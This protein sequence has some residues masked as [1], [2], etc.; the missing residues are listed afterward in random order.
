MT[1]EIY[2]EAIRKLATIA[3]G[4]T[5][6]SRVAAQVLLSAYNGQAFQVNIVDLCIF[7]K[8]HY[9]A[10]LSVIRGRNELGTEPHTLLDNGDQIF[11]ELWQQWQRYHVENRAKPT[12][13]LCYGSGLIPEYPDDENNYSQTTCTQCEGRGY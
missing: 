5:G 6:G 3:Q 8:E 11:K 10:A 4:D 7:D 1:P 13:N 12:C 9:H 2:A